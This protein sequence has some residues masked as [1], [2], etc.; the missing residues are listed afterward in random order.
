MV[1]PAGNTVS[2]NE[3]Q[4]A[5]QDGKPQ[6]KRTPDKLSGFFTAFRNMVLSGFVTDLNSFDV[7]EEFWPGTNFALLFRKT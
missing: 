1:K 4:I 3:Y 5:S 6:W 7:F 2:A